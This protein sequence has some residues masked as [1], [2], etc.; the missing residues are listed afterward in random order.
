MLA[1]AY[2]ELSGVYHLR[3]E[4]EPSERT[5]RLALELYESFGDLRSVARVHLQLA[6]IYRTQLEQRP[7]TQLASQA[8]KHLQSAESALRTLDDRLGQAILAWEAARLAVACQEKA[9]AAALFERA[10]HLFGAAGNRGGA[11]ACANGSG[12]LLREM[13]HLAEAETAYLSFIKVSDEL[14]SSLH[15]GTGRA[16][17]GWVELARGNFEGANQRFEEALRTFGEKAPI[18]HT[19]PARV[20]HLESLLHLER[21]T[22]AMALLEEWR[23]TLAPDAIDRDVTNSLERAQALA[24]ASGWDD[25]VEALGALR[26]EL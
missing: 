3:G 16:N 11:A 20:G 1:D 18:V 10:S 19:G 14:G 17:L 24:Q 8:Q 15:A 26:M 2:Q 21:R 12:E 22:E 4:L 7:S 9:R 5:V 13:G 6:R 23:S 25:V